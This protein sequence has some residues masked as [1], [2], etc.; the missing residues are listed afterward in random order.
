MGGCQL[1]YEKDLLELVRV[2][3]NEVVEPVLCL[4]STVSGIS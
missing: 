1:K 3:V 4:S 2:R